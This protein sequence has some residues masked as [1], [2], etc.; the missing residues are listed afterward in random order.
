M[1]SIAEGYEV[2]LPKRHRA[3]SCT[4]AYPVLDITDLTSIHYVRYATVIPN[5]PS[6][7]VMSHTH[8]Q[9]ANTKCPDANRPVMGLLRRR[10]G[11]HS[12]RLCYMSQTLPQPLGITKKKALGQELRTDAERG[13]M[14]Q[15]ER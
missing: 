11:P 3:N 5:A 9:R 12:A 14:L 1:Q 13:A 7:Q 15:S 8:A 10:G 4:S 2:P 6:Q